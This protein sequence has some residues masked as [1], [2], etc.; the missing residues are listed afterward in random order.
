M[1]RSPRGN[2][3]RGQSWTVRCLSVCSTIITRISLCLRL[4][5][6]ILHLPTRLLLVQNKFNINPFLL[7]TR[8]FQLA[9]TATLL[10]YSECQTTNENWY[11]WDRKIYFWKLKFYHF[12]RVV[13]SI[14]VVRDYLYSWCLYTLILIS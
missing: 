3:H 8:K 10:F 1:M 4:N 14:H 9:I 5:Y 11:L 7:C 13:W 2:G 12:I 6:E